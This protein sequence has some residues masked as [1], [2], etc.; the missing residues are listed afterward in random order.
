LGNRT[1]LIVGGG[2]IGL[3]IAEALS[4]RGIKPIVLEKGEFGR[5]ASWAGTGS[6][7]LKQAVLAGGAK[8]DL[9]VF[10]LRLFNQ[11]MDLLHQESGVDPEYYIGPALEIAFDENEENNLKHL[12]HR[13]QSLDMAVEWKTGDEARNGEP[14]I[15][16]EILSAIQMP[17]MGLVRPPRLMRALMTLLVKRGVVLRDQTPVSG[18]LTQGGKVLG[19]RT[20]HEEIK[21]DAVVLAGGAWSGPLGERLGIKIPVRPMRGQVAL[22]YS[23]RFV[24][25]SVLT[26][27]QVTL[28][29]RADGHY[30]VSTSSE[31]VGF[32]KNTTLQGV[33]KIESGAYRV[34]PGL[35]LAKMES[36]WAGLLPGNPDGRPFL[37]LVPE[38][39]G[40]YLACGHFDQGFLLAPATGLLMDQMLRGEEPDI[41]IEPFSLNRPIQENFGL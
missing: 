27:S 28:V 33:E 5:E 30:H 22:F 20:S 41:D 14:E 35:R 10:S 21:A 40:L 23:D 7:S 18:F 4:R 13:L 11:W 1:I 31:D 32:N 8:L 29:P 37:G 38:I 12:F 16:T 15:S 3:S 19:V 6:L 9:S 2:I 39:E 17:Q 36:R 24:V 34:A 26:T 25:K